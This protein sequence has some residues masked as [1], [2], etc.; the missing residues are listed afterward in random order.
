MGTKKRER[1]PERF[2]TK[3]RSAIQ[4]NMSEHNVSKESSLSVVLISRILERFFS[5]KHTH[6]QKS[7][8]LR[9]RN[10]EKFF[11]DERVPEICR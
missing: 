2:T 3:A 10:F 5:P 1:L 7:T 8:F 6:K 9:A 11:G 4:S